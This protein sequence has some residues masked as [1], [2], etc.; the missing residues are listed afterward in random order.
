EWSF[1][2]RIINITIEDEQGDDPRPRLLRLLV[3]SLR[4]GEL[5]VGGR[6]SIGAGIISLKDL[7]IWRKIIED[8]E[9]R[10]VEVRV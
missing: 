9:I 10:A 7:R 2:M 8:G 4:N 1:N 5:Q 3:S 6:K